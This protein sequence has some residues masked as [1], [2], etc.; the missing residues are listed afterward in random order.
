VFVLTG[1]LPHLTR[2]EA[3]ALIT[4]A[5]GRVTSSVTRKTDYVVAGTDP[6]SKYA[7]AQRLK[8]P[9]LDEDDLYQLLHAEPRPLP[10]EER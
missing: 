4:A 2:Q 8:I 10:T 9:I 5:G 6:G 1:T 3:Q 7:Q